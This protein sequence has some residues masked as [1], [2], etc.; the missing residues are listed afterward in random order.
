M[1]LTPTET[2][3]IGK[4]HIQVSTI[5]YHEDDDVRESL[6][7]DLTSPPAPLDLT[8]STPTVHD[9]TSSPAP[10]DLTVSTHTVLPWVI[11]RQPLHDLTAPG[12]AFT[13]WTI[14]TS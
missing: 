2:A 5:Q 1:T 14:L 3:I 8:I 9:L 13:E 4:V 11:D 12:P 6:V 7:H 10:V